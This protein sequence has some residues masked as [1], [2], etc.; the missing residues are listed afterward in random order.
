MTNPEKNFD[1]KIEDILSKLTLKEKIGQLNMQVSPRNDQALAD[2]MDQLRRGEFGSMILAN[3]D[4]AGNDAP[5][6]VNT[7]MCNKVQK[8]AVEEGPHGIPIIYGRDIIH[9]YRTIFPIPLAASASFND[10]LVEKAARYSAIE[11]SAVGVHWTF[12]PMLDMC[13]DPRYGRII[14]GPGEDPVVGRHMAKSMIKGYQNGDVSKEDSLLTCAK[15]FV[16]YGA[17]EG[18]R[19]YY[20]TEIAPYTLYNYYIPAFRE[21]VNAGVDTVMPSFNDISGEPV[22]G[23]KHYLTDVLRKDLGF[24]GLLVSDWAA[25]HY[26]ADQGI[27]ANDK[28][29][30]EV[31]INAGME[32][33]MCDNCFINNLEELIN[34]GKVSMETLD[35]AV[36]SVLRLKFKKNLFEN[37]Y[38][39]M[40]QVDRTEHLKCAKELASECMV[41]LK[42]EGNVLPLPKDKRIGL[43]G[44]FVHEKRALLGSWCSNGKEAETPSLC[45][46][47]LEK[48]GA[49][50]IIT[51]N[52]HTEIDDVASAVIFHSDIL[53]LALGESHRVTGE[54]R[55][56]SDITLTPSQKAL[57]KKAKASGKKV[58]G[59]F[60][61]G[62]PLALEGIAEYLDAVLYAWHAGSETASAAADILYGDIV[63]SGKTVITFPRQV[64]HI[65]MY[66]NATKNRFNCY[67]GS[68]ADFSY[69]DSTATPYYPFGYGLSYTTFEYSPVKTDVSEISLEDVQKGKKITCSVTVTN[70]G[71]YDGKETVQLYLRDV[72][73]KMMR[74]YREL[75][76][77]NKIFLKKG[78][79]KTVEFTIGYDELGYYLADGSY[80]L[81]K[82]D[83][84]VLIGENSL[85]KNLAKIKVI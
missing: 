81:E 64:G 11:A 23:S 49:D 12:S 1:A 74:P 80:I 57:V 16:G 20:R 19:D 44:P 47:M 62:R 55:S 25:V 28:E 43:L 63:P 37:P 75:K 8:I 59:V 77:Y 10:E 30:T 36:R 21:A 72:V 71:D 33:D 61:C 14:E 70:T 78:E 56:L 18:G 13:H 79:S 66:Y 7:A 50:K 41:L 48:F 38:C 15:H 35:N 2:I 73:G 17:S 22:S 24:E 42:N 26:L 53:V 40:P 82:G 27:T 51:E 9:G 4:T 83:F 85:T 45:E 58:V 29:S 67:Y 60:F 31:G 68:Y 6:S 54:R 34:E 32:I 84:E 3:S 65:P 69:E 76:D 39:K 52:N 5:E 46:K